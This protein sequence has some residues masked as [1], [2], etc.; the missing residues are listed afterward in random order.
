MCVESLIDVMVQYALLHCYGVDWGST[1]DAVR[2]AINAIPLDKTQ[3]NYSRRH[4]LNII[5]TD[6]EEICTGMEFSL[7][8]TEIS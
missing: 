1:P 4:T 8:T 6:C 2:D 5:R 3:K 7:T